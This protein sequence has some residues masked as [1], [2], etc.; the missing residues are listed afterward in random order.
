M[1]IL[2][3]GSNARGQL[4]NGSI[5]DSHQFQPV[6]WAGERPTAQVKRIACGGNHTL[7]LF[8]DGQLWVSGDGRRG[9]LGPIKSS[10]VFTRLKLED[11]SSDAEDYQILDVTAAWE[12]SYIVL[13]RPGAGDSI[14]SMGA[15]D[16]GD[17]GI[18]RV[19]SKD[20]PPTNRISFDQ[21]LGSD[22]DAASVRIQGI[23]AGPHHV[24]VSLDAEGQGGKIH[25]LV[26]GWGASRHGQLGASSAPKSPT[27]Y[28]TP[29][30]LTLQSSS[31][32]VAISAGNQHTVVLHS[33]GG[34][35]FYGTNKKSQLNCLSS[36]P[37]N[38]KAIHCTWNGTCLVSPVDNSY[39]LYLSGS[40][41][42]GQ[43]GILDSETDPHRLQ[44]QR[45]SDRLLQLS[46]GSEHILAHLKGPDESLVMGWG[47][48]EHGNLGLGHTDDVGPPNVLWPSSGGP[49]SLSHVQ[50][51]WAGCGTS[52]I[53]FE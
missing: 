21:F 38:V 18:G 36:P 51:V 45:G 17:R 3:A 48:N 27:S 47:W 7:I 32:P 13:R 4:A 37:P 46:A 9:Q 50:S 30:T 35:S 31:V 22:V 1:H 52:F 19:G 20:L 40:N 25:H 8:E 6:L 12:T 24:V 23:D 39:S 42:H 44:F 28:P 53:V 26:V 29:C 11:L 2:S 41:A 49:G 10:L 16:F 33:D 43:L 15:N 14:L 34:L 5:E